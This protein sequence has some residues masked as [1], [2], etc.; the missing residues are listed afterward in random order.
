VEREEFQEFVQDLVAELNTHVFGPIYDQLQKD[1]SL[2]EGLN[3]AFP[4]P[5]TIRVGLLDDCLAV[6]PA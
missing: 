1:D 6:E 5:N 3:P 4:F 2:R